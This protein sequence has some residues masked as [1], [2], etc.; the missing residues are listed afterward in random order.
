MNMLYAV[1]CHEQDTQTQLVIATTKE[2]LKT[3]LSGMYKISDE[4]FD[5]LIVTSY[6]NLS[7]NLNTSNGLSTKF[8][9]LSLDSTSF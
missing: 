5:D 4:N 7:Y 9:S 8:V 3:K 1:M 2:Q 6:S